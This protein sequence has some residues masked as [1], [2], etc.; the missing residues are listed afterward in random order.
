MENPVNQQCIRYTDTISAEDCDKLRNS[1]QWPQMHI[2]QII[3]GLANSA[4]IIAAKDG[5]Q[6]VGMVRV[7]SDGGYVFFIVDVLVLPEYQHKGIGKTMMKRAME[8]IYS[9]LREGYCI[10]VDLLASKGKEGFYEEF[11]F[12]KRPD[13]NYGCGMT[14]RIEK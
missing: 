7:V 3:T 1:A 10:Q 9:S 12:I 11:G 6:T 14:L 5:E 4:F 13:D 2:E 8:Y